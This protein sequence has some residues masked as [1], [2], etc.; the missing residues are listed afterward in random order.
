M[1]SQWKVSDA[2]QDYDKDYLF[3]LLCNRSFDDNPPNAWMQAV[4]HYL[5]GSHLLPEVGL[6]QLD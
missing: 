4:E 3:N 5:W 2:L 1:F 6:V